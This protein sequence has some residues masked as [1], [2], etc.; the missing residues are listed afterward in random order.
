MTPGA[1]PG[2]V[3]ATRD[4]RAY[5][6]ALGKFLP[7]EPVGNDSVEGY[8]GPLDARQRRIKNK[9]LQQNGIATRHYALDRTGR[10]LH[11]NAGMAAAAARDAL[12]RSELV[13]GELEMLAAA[14]SQGDLLAPGF[15]SQ[16]QGELGLPQAEIASFLSFCA[17]GMMAVKSAWSNILGGQRRNGLVCASEF[18]SRFLRAGYLQGADTSTDSEFLRWMLSDG[19][20]AMV[21]EDRPNRQGLSLRVEFVDLV[22]YAGRFETCMY[23][24]ALKNGGNRPGLPWSNYPSLQDAVA[25]GAFHLRQDLKLLDNI[26]LLGVRRY[27]ELVEAGRID[28]EAVDHALYHFSSEVFRGK[29][30]RAAAEA[31]CPIDEDRLFTNLSSKGNTGSASI[32]IMLDELFNERVLSPGQKILCVVPESGRFIVATMLLTVVGPEEAEANGVPVETAPLATAPATAGEGP[33][34]AELKASLIRQLTLVWSD[35]EAEL[36]QVPVIDKLN[37]GKLR[38]EDYKLVLLNLRQQ[39]VEGARWIARAASNITAEGFDLRSTFLGHAHEEHRDF[40]ML[41]RNYVAVGGTLEEIQGAEKNIGS[42]ALSAWMFHKASREN[43][44]DLL[45]AM[46]VI[47]GLG[48]RLALKWGQAFQDQLGLTPEQ[49]SFLLYHGDNDDRHLEKMWEAFDSGILTPTL[50]KDIVKTAKV[51]ARLYRLQL[52]ELGRT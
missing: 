38:L 16:V 12:G 35:F 17:S 31:G 11:S 27:F 3:E 32:F 48:N 42:E 25:D 29:T 6:T 20:G 19:A 30:I 15:A 28:P 40:Q 2:P 43:P 24:G 41:E 47:E 13:L 10:P 52:E 49:V 18:A 7:G 8:L 21:L 37:R 1:L 34:A 4:R 39:V 51:T 50:V 22:S 23:G 5:I 26:V 9:A 36:N 33:S 45:G 46:F 44:I 14:S